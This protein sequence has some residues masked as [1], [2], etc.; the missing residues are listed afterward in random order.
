MSFRENVTVHFTHFYCYSYDEFLNKIILNCYLCYFFVSYLFIS[1]TYE[2]RDVK[3]LG[4]LSLVHESFSSFLL[5]SSFLL[6]PSLDHFFIMVSEKF[7]SM[8]FIY[9]KNI[10]C[11]L[12]GKIWSKTTKLYVWD[13]IWQIEYFEFV[14]DY[15]FYCYGPKI[16]FFGKLCPKYQ[17]C[18]FKM[19]LGTYNPSQNMLGPFYNIKWSRTFMESLAT[20]FVQFFV[21]LPS[22]H[23]GTETGH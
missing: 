17:N 18:L 9:D 11:T 6:N 15:H 14:S 10:I 4:E 8:G 3:M 13:K 21:P 16:P 12:F 23:F 1:T 2:R 22:F 7:W 20:D 19:K 5:S